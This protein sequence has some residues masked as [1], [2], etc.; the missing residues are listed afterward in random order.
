M[1]AKADGLEA[2]VRAVL[3]EL[4]RRPEAAALDRDDDLVERLGLDSLQGLRVLAALEKRFGARFP[5]AWLGE[6]RTI[7]RLVEAVGAQRREGAA[8]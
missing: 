7:R 6:L 1:G 3:V 5:D 2:R 8:P 4:T